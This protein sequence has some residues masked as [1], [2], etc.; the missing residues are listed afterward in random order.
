MLADLAAIR[1]QAYE[2]GDYV[3]IKLARMI[4]DNKICKDKPFHLIGHSAGGF[5]V[6]RIAVLL[7]ELGLVPNKDLLR[8]TILDTP[9]PDDPVLKE[10]PKYWPT[11]FCLTSYSV[12]ELPFDAVKEVPGLHVLKPK[13]KEILTEL[14]R[15]G[16]DVAEGRWR[17]WYWIRY[18]LWGWISQAATEFWKA[19][20]SAYGWFELTI[21]KNPKYANE[22]FNKSPLLPQ[23]PAIGSPCPK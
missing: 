16:R 1:P 4:N 10:L 8:V 14:A 18:Y 9:M 19:H 20:R 2:V 13:Y 15:P 17:S 23:P 21:N 3:A 22:G 11:D 6:A 5:V 7:S 12:L